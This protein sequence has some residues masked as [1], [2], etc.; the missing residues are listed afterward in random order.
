MNNDPMQS[1]ACLTCGYR[2][3][4]L[5][6]PT[7]PECGRPFDP[8][9]ADTYRRESGLTFWAY[10]AKPPTRM[11]TICVL[12]SVLFWLVGVSRISK[13][14]LLF[15]PIVGQE[16]AGRGMVVLLIWSLLAGIYVLHVVGRRRIRKEWPAHL[17][18]AN[19]RH[20][21]RC[22]AIP[23]LLCIGLSAFIYPWPMRLR[24]LLDRNKL[25]QIVQNAH[26]MP[27]NNVWVGS[28]SVILSVRRNDDDHFFVTKIS[29]EY[30]Y[31]YVYSSQPH[32]CPGFLDSYYPLDAHWY[33]GVQA[34]P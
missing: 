5:P 27:S 23:L 29:P 19:R 22:L 13:A 34:N 1:A 8:D 31:G 3:V 28:T 26:P 4:G 11:L 20:T 21:F 15:Q 24:F 25:Q 12:L 16:G 33:V 6:E 10:F 30:D 14:M 9:D 32:Q 7:C 18:F 17:F 2:L